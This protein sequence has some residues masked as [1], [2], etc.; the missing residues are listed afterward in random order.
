MACN[1]YVGAALA[2]DI[3]AACE[4]GSATSDNAL[5]VADQGGKCASV[6]ALAIQATGA[7]ACA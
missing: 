2:L 6:A 5:P 1:V 4:A 3:A 7:A